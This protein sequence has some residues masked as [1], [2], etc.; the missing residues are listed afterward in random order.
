M[1]FDSRGISIV[2]CN[3]CGIDISRCNSQL[4]LPKKHYCSD[5]CSWKSKKKGKFI[6]CHTCGKE[7]WKRPSYLHDNGIEY[8]SRECCCKFGFTKEHKDNLSKSKNH[9]LTPINKSIRNHLVDWRK[10]IYKRDD[11]TCQLCYVKG[12]N[13]NAH[14]IKSFAKYPDERFNINNGITLCIKCHKWVHHIYGVG[15]I[16]I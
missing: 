9:G 8:C 14:H 2:Q 11:Y 3:Y 10:E 6:K 5:E 15:K 4:R 1:S 7:L 16:V 13:L 12:G